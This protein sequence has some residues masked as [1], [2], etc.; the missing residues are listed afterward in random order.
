MHFVNKCHIEFQLDTNDLC[1]IKY[2][3]K[4]M[5]I[6]IIVAARELTISIVENCIYTMY[7]SKQE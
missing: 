3:D 2:N 4:Q 1:S 7:A 5:N 6:F